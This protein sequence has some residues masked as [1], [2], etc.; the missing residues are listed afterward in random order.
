MA[1]PAEKA[2]SQIKVRQR[3]V[4]AKKQ[5]ISH[6]GEKAKSPD[7]GALDFHR[8]DERRAEEVKALGSGRRYTH[9]LTRENESELELMRVRQQRCSR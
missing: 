7:L 6:F 1:P 3:L 4:N 8:Y 5:S 2:S 9:W